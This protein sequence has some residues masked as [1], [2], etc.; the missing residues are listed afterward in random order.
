MMFSATKSRPTTLQGFDDTFRSW[1]G[2]KR[3]QRLG[4]VVGREID[5]D[6]DTDFQTI[7]YTYA[8]DSRLTVLIPNRNRCHA[9]LYPPADA[10]GAAKRER[11]GTFPP[12]PALRAWL[13][14]SHL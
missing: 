13:R 10:P 14:R 6:L 7:Q 9:T 1:V 5:V 2:E 3:M 12:T 11:L 8:D 4:Q